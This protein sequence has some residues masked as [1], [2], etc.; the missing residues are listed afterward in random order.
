MAKYTKTYD[1]CA[2]MIFCLLKVQIALV[3]YSQ[4]PSCHHKLPNVYDSPLCWVLPPPRHARYVTKL[5]KPLL[6]KLQVE[7]WEQSRVFDCN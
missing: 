3:L 5:H 2:E 1:E 6:I 7:I 4:S